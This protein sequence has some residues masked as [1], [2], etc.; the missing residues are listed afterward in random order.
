MIILVLLLSIFLLMSLVAL[1]TYMVLYYR[2]PKQLGFHYKKPKEKI[3]QDMFHIVQLI[4]NSSQNQACLQLFKFIS[5]KLND[6]LKS[7]DD[8]DCI[9]AQSKV[10]E[11]LDNLPPGIDQKT[12]ILIKKLFDDIMYGLC[13]NGKLNSAQLK[14]VIT[15][16]YSSTCYQEW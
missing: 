3:N 6:A 5:D 4:I 8:I 1:V 11:M 14:K 2:V 15:D 16:I 10:T 7:I 12:K 13:S 9:E